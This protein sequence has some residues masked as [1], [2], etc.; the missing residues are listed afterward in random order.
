MLRLVCAVS[1]TVIHIH[2]YAETKDSGRYVTQILTLLPEHLSN[3]EKANG[4]LKSKVQNL[5]LQ[6]ILHF[7]NCVLS[8]ISRRRTTVSSD[9]STPIPVDLNPCDFL[10]VQLCEG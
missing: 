5:K 4:C 6:T 2:Q 10:L 1:A 7:E 3:Y 9:V 8:E